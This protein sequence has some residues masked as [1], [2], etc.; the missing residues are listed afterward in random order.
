[1]FALRT[2]RTGWTLL[3]LRTLGSIRTERAISASLTLRPISPVVAWI[4]LVAF[5]SLH[6]L[7]A[8]GAWFSLRASLTRLALWTLR[9]LATLGVGSGECQPALLPVERDVSDKN[10][11]AHIRRERIRFTPRADLELDFSLHQAAVTVTV[12][13]SGV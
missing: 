7:L 11:R 13:E 5:V 10:D 2:I 3:A 9:P 4:S 6:P 8:L 1:M 12:G